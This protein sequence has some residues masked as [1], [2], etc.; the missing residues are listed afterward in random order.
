MATS[1][2]VRAKTSRRGAVWVAAYRALS[3]PLVAGGLAR[4][5]RV[6][7]DGEHL[8]VVFVGREQRFRRWMTR[9]LGGRAR[10][11]Q[12][13]VKLA[14]WNPSR[15]WPAD[16][17]LVAVELHPWLA[18]RF[19]ASGWLICPE[20]IGWQGATPQLPPAGRNTSVQ[21]D[22]QRVA[23]GGYELHPATGSKVDWDEFRNEML[24][25]YAERRFGEDARIPSAALMRHLRARGRL[26]L[27]TRAGVRLAGVGVLCSAN[28][29]WLTALGVKDGDPALLREGVLAALYVLTIGWARAAG[30][31]RID[32]AGAPAF[33]LD[34]LTQY[35]RKW[36]LSPVVEPLSPLIAARIDPDCQALRRAME[37]EPFMVQHED[38][39]E[40]HPRS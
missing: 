19:R 36:G 21:S 25:P 10:L 34:G 6:V 8:T 15:L 23:K 7:L 9:V 13:S 40:L 29:V 5:Y 24:V 35:K 12:V 37:R 27:V 31:H 11:E 4:R 3:L 30:M 18:N 14:L 38:A 28:T 20:S 17:A 26:L 2:E 33:Q 22:L 39:L 16:A 1:I 32:F